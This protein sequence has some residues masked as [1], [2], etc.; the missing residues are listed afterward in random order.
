MSVTPTSSR[1]TQAMLDSLRQA[2]A[3][4]LERKKRLGQYALSGITTPRS[5]LAMM[6]P[7][8]CKPKTK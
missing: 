7:D 2:V 1:E 3:Q 6:P 8:P 4:T 5:R